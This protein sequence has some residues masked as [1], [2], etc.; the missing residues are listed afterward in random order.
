MQNAHI[1]VQCYFIPYHAIDRNN[2][3]TIFI[4]SSAG[5][6][7]ARVFFMSYML[8][9]T[10]FI[11]SSAGGI[12]ARVFFMS[13]MLCYISKGKSITYGYYVKGR[14]TWYNVHISN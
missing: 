6:I 3:H 10:I 1:K 13:Y 14:V 11:I 4:I 2:V 5:G 7:V 12:V 9:H 8:C